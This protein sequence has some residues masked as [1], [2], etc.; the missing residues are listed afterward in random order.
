LQTDFTY[1]LILMV[2]TCENI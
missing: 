1:R 2:V